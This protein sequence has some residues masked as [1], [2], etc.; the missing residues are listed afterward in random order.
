MALIDAINHCHHKG[1]VHRDLNPAN[2]LLASK[3]E[4]APITIVGFGSACSVLDGPITTKCLTPDF[5][6]P[7]ILLEKLHGKVYTCIRIKSGRS[8]ERRL[9]WR[10]GGESV[11]LEEGEGVGRG[12]GRALGK[13]TI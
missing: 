11:V 2:I 9:P 6:P 8:D 12:E 7:E 4:D 10:G 13:R 5:S 1:I 3:H